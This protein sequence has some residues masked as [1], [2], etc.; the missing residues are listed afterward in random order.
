MYVFM[1]NSN[2]FNSVEKMI[3][4]SYKLCE[5]ALYKCDV[6]VKELS[7]VRKTLNN[8]LNRIKSKKL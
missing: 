5:R 1:D 8:N 2:Q 3:A 6:V 7:Q 4:D